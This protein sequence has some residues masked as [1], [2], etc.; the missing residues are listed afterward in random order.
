MR[1]WLAF[2]LLALPRSAV[3]EAPVSTPTLEVVVRLAGPAGGPPVAAQLCREPLAGEGRESSCSAVK[4]PGNATLDLVG[5]ASW[6]LWLTAPQHWAATEVVAG[7]RPTP[8]VMW[9]FPTGRLTGRIAGPPGQTL[10]GELK[11][12]FSPTHALR[13]AQPL[14]PAPPLPAASVICPLSNEVLE[15]EI[16][17]GVLDLKVEMPGLAPQYL[18]EQRVRPETP[19]NL[20]RIALQRGASVSGWVTHDGDRLAAEP[21]EAA[22]VELSPAI[23]TTAAD[24][25]DEQTSARLKLRTLATTVNPRGFFQLVDVP[26]GSYAL[27]VQQP[28]LALARIPEIQV[29]ADAETR[30]TAPIELHPPWKVEVFV[31]PP[32]SPTDTPWDLTFLPKSRQDLDDFHRGTTD[33][34]GSATF[35]DLAPGT[36]L[37][38]VETATPTPSGN[39]RTVWATQEVELTADQAQVQIRISWVPLVGRV[40]AGK[41]PIETTLWFVGN[42][43]RERIPLASDAEGRFTGYL[44]REGTWEVEVSPFTASPAV[45]KLDPVAVAKVVGKE[46]AEVEIRIPTTRL[47][48]IVVDGDRPVSNAVILLA[49]P[50]RKSREAQAISDAAGEFEIRGVRAGSAYLWAQAGDRT[51]E[52]LPLEIQEGRDLTEIRLVVRPQ[53][54]FRGQVVSPS[55]GVPGALI[56]ATPETS[57]AARGTTPA[58]VRRVLSGP[59]GGFVLALPAEANAATMLVL[60]PGNSLRLLRIDLQAQGR[61]PLLLPVSGEGGTLVLVLGNADAPAVLQHGN[62]LVHLG[63]LREWSLR[64]GGGWQEDQGRLIVPQVESGD[65]ALCWASSLKP[66]ATPGLVANPGCAYGNLL[67]H[68]ELLLDLTSHLQEPQPPTEL[69]GAPNDQQGDVTH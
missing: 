59:D 28:G 8:Q 17:A 19:L 64:H 22:R 14:D 6:K 31:D 65:Y 35:A 58:L 37:L 11:I 40:F 69:Q 3:A 61:S 1:V 27:T 7:A 43:G 13:P 60:P 38:F 20:G 52:W 26:P 68:R 18:W 57:A 12:S 47:S 4:T 46:A 39:A 36:Y 25:S 30:L 32:F 63:V 10:S 42:Q 15:C 49:S 50:E 55:G 67:P 29:L 41:D 34:S 44:P 45:Q 33:L 23:V 66:A 16:P 9:L 2:L 54:D 56:T 53:V 62:A 51:S 24:L 48:G 5:S 21:Q